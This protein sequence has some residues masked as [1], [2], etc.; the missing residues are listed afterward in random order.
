MTLFN[1]QD[2]FGYLSNGFLLRGVAVTLGLTVATVIGGMLFG[3][4]VA[5]MRMSGSKPLA[6]A[7]QFY[8]WF[9]R[10]T[11]LLIQL[12]IV[13]TGLPQLGLRLNVVESSLLA[14]IL[15]EAAYLAEII[16]SGFMGVPRGQYEAA[17]A[18]GL[19]KWL[20]MWKVTLPQAFRLMI[21]SLGNSINGLL[22]STSITSVISM[23]EL[24]RRSQML[25]QE[26]FEVLEV[27]GAAAVF[28]LVM[29]TGWGLI[30]RRLEK[31]FGAAHEQNR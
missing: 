31:H 5:L 27:F 26:K 7:A 10:G 20:V 25:M 18:L 11:P 17:E 28:Y 23:E 2:F 16:R 24:M 30:Q 8:I 22:K 13:Y 14:L 15:N 6:G 19:P 29:T 21:P 9:F 1:L 12:V 3:M 4:L